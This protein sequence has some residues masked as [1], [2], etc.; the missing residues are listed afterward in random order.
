LEVDKIMIL[1]LILKLGLALVTTL[2]GAYILFAGRRALWATLGILALWV[3]AN[4]LAVLVAGVS[5]GQ[6]LL[7]LQDWTLLGIS[8]AAGVLG[9]LI[10][11]FLQGLAMS[12]IGFIAGSDI[13]LWL[14]DIA[15]YVVTDLA[16]LSEQ[17]ALIVGVALILIGGLVG[18]W[19]IRKT[20][21]EGVILITMIIGVEVIQDALGLNTASSW[22]A[23]F[24]LSLALA[25]VLVQYTDHMRG[26]KAS[27]TLDD[28]PMP[29]SSMTQFQDLD[30][31][32]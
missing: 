16:N 7:A 32:V 9:M 31:S 14:Y 6:E 2:A 10:G 24:I 28:P 30:L 21:D 26:I 15:A 8:L 12:L 29:E 1:E 19:F 25:G 11:R 5:N 23:I 17:T 13:A 22:T 18:F 27:S 4:L 3:T 20:R